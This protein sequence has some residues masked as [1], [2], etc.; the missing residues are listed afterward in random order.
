VHAEL[1][2]RYFE[3]SNE[4]AGAA[5]TPREVIRLMVNS[6]FAED[7]AARIGSAVVRILFDLG[8]GTSGMLSVPG[9]PPR[10]ETRDRDGERR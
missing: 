1:I 8:C 4:T 9:S 3:L 2:R 7:D 10:P 5:F 6:R